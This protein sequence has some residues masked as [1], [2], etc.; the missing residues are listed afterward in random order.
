[1]ESAGTISQQYYPDDGIMERKQQ[2]PRIQVAQ[3]V[4]GGWTTDSNG[5][6]V[7]I[8]PEDHY[9]QGIEEDG[10]FDI[11]EEVEDDVEME[12]PKQTEETKEKRTFSPQAKKGL[13]LAIMLVAGLI[14]TGCAMGGQFGN[15]F[16]TQQPA[17]GAAFLVPGTIGLVGS[18]IYGS[19]K[20]KEANV[21][22][23]APP[24]PKHAEPTVVDTGVRADGLGSNED[25]DEIGSLE[26]V[27]L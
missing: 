5:S 26:E 15:N 12:Q 13:I 9:G 6:V 27:S 8:R 25:D 17:I 24:A 19:R 21:E 22:D 10:A 18:G 3:E 16:L 7:D 4:I 1:M 23:K 14:L 2:S 20:P 11:E